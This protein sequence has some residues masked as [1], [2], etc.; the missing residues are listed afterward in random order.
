[1]IQKVFGS[2]SLLKAAILRLHKRLPDHERHRNATLAPSN[3]NLVLPLQ[4]L[5]LYPIMIFPS[6]LCKD[7]PKKISPLESCSY[8]SSLDALLEGSS[9]KGL[10]D[11]SL[12][13]TGEILSSP[14]DSITLKDSQ[15]TYFEEF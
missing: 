6:F 5:M 11:A 1:M 14:K 10:P 2:E 3:P 9:L 7:S 13:R 8:Q 15:H 12:K 4:I